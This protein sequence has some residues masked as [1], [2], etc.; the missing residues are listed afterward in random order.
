[1]TAKELID[2][3]RLANTITPDLI[4]YF[5]FKPVL[6]DDKICD[7]ENLPFRTEVVEGLLPN[8]S[9]KDHQLIRKLFTEELKCE[10]AIGR[11]DN[12]YQL[13]YYLYS[14]GDLE[15][16][17][18]IYDAKFNSKNMDTGTVLD[19]E[20]LYI[21]H[22]V[23]EVIQFVEHKIADHPELKQ[24]WPKILET[25]NE[26]KKSD[27]VTDFEDYSKFIKGYFFGHDN[28]EIADEQTEYK[29]ITHPIAEKK[30]KQTFWQWLLRGLKIS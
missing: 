3:T 28:G 5:A 11:H 14:L 1:M 23:D 10:L 18:L 7:D 8:F 15:D 29:V 30:R 17:F 22:P 13:C 2:N 6:Q 26:L 27:Y 21:S 19:W 25:L 9:L 20:M 16:V 12:L 4:G 24:K